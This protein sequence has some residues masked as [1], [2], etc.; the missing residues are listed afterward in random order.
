MLTRPGSIDE[1]YLERGDV[2][3]HRPVLQG[4]VFKGIVIP[5]VGLEHD[6]I[7]VAMHPCTM[8]RGPHLVDRVKAHPVTAHENV[9]LERWGDSYFR[10]YPLP[11]LRD[12]QNCAVRF[13]EVGMIPALELRRERRV[14]T[15]SD[16]GILLFQQRQVFADTRAVISIETL[17]LASAAVL[18]EAELLEEWNEHLVTDSENDELEAALRHQA[19]E[20]DTY[21]GATTEKTTLREMLRDEHS[22][23]AVRKAVRAEVRRRV[24]AAG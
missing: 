10:V 12:G 1:I 6:L 22:R 15:L 20:F 4:D 7:A 18:A 2:S 11:E 9:D 3:P 17:G 5:G 14:A 13:D 19:V 23:S 8:R 24:A 16:R 21:L